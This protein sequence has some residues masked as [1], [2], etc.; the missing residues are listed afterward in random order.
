MNNTVNLLQNE[1]M[2][3][4]LVDSSDGDNTDLVGMIAYAIYKAEKIDY[5]ENHKNTECGTKPTH[6][7]LLA[8]QKSKIQKSST[9]YKNEAEKLLFEAVNYI[10][11]DEAKKLKDKDERLQKLIIETNKEKKEYTSLKKKEKQKEKFCKAVKPNGFF[12]GVFQSLVASIILIILTILLAF[13]LKIDL[14]SIL[15]ELIN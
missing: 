2:Y 4:S 15:K 5:I 14:L 12:I 1:S 8:F 3:Y 7:K 11:K 13:S 6:E 10:L 9:F